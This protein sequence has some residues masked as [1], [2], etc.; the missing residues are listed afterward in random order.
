M[1]TKTYVT[2]EK[3]PSKMFLK[4]L[5]SGGSSEI[6]CHCGR[7]H[8]A[9]GNLR[10]SDDEDDYE[11]MLN[12]VEAEK[13]ANPDGVIIHDDDFVYYYLFDSSV[14]VDECPCN[15]LRRYEDFIWN[16]RNT[17]REYYKVRVAQEAKW[18]ADDV[19]CNKLVGI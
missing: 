12:T 7:M 17:I 16:N 14:Y 2:R 6:E 1:T 15:G 11:C 5:Q 19:L 3:R 8:Y 13:A 4:T 18:A 10:N 9:P